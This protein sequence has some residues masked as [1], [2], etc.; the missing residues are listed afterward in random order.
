MTYLVTGGRRRRPPAV[1][2]RAQMAR[3]RTPRAEAD[4][5][6][7]VAHLPLRPRAPDGAAQAVRNHHVGDLETAR[8]SPIRLLDDR[9]RGIEP[10]PVLHVGLGLACRPGEEVGRLSGRRGMD[11]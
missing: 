9:D 8:H 1:M 7:R 3:L 10:E 2:T 11:R 4:D 6:L 5:D